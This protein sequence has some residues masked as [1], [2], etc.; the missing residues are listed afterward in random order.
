MFK[1]KKPF[2]PNI[3]DHNISTFERVVLCDIG[4][5]EN[6]RKRI[7]YN[8]SRDESMALRNLARGKNII[9][10]QADKG[11]GVVLLDKKNYETEVFR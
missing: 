3:I 6:K 11:G 4:I 2:V 8:I 5:M 7:Q 1:P 9:I 10:K